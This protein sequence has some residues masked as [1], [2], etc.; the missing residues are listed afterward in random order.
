[1]TQKEIGK[2]NGSQRRVPDSARGSGSH[3]RAGRFSIRI[4][5]LAGR[6]RERNFRG[7]GVLCQQLSADRRVA[8]PRKTATVEEAA[9]A[10]CCGMAGSFGYESEHY[11]I[12]QQIGERKLLP[13]IRNRT[14][15]TVVVA[16]GFSCRHQIQHFT[17]VKAVSAAELL[18]AQLSTFDSQLSTTP[19][20]R[21]SPGRARSSGGG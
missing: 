7:R 19:E 5:P 20:S 11:D 18:N 15:D 13:A 1:M 17:D 4:G 6:Q 2:K 8:R 21:E 10:G 16:S 9:D 14:N 12:S 3:D